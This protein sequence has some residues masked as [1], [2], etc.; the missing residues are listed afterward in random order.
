MQN[1]QQPIALPANY[2]LNAKNAT[3]SGGANN[4][5]TRHNATIGH[6]TIDNVNFAHVMPD[7]DLKIDLPCLFDA[8]LGSKVALTMHVLIH[9]SD[10]NLRLGNLRDLRQTD[11]HTTVGRTIDRRNVCNRQDLTDATVAA[12]TA[13]AT[14]VDRTRRVNVLHTVRNATTVRGAD[15]SHVCAAHAT[16]TIRIRDASLYEISAGASKVTHTV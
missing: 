7:R 15:I 16:L 6:V 1:S 4:A 13:A 11:K 12:A 9:R 14:A 5:S 2:F 3:S 8:Q 10:R